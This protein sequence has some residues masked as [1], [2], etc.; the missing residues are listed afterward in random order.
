MLKPE[1][2]HS[3]TFLPDV[4][5]LDV[6]VFDVVVLVVVEVVVI[7]VVVVVVVVLLVVVVEVVVFV[8][9]ILSVVVSNSQIKPNVCS[10]ASPESVPS[11]VLA[12]SIHL[13][14]FTSQLLYFL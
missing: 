11:A 1:F 10:P 14:A 13:P 3:A 8:V 5:I 9:V 2:S 7:F 12:V 4:V 6:V